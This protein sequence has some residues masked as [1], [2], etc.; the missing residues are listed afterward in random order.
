MLKT[1]YYETKSLKSR[2]D[3]PVNG[4]PYR[5]FVCNCRLFSKKR[6]D[7]IFYRAFLCWYFKFIGIL[8]KSF[9]FRKQIQSLLFFRCYFIFRHIIF[10]IHIY[11]GF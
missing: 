8:I 5:S 7:D 1:L 4:K 3:I 2:S 9:S 6:G 10:S 11:D